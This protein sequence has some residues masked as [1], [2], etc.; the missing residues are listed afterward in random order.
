MSDFKCP[1]KVI[2]VWID[3]DDREVR[4]VEPCGAQLHL[5]WSFDWPLC[6]DLPNPNIESG[7]IAQMAYTDGWGVV[8]ENG[9]KLAM[10]AGQ[11]NAEA[12]SIPQTMES[13]GAL[14]TFDKTKMR[15]SEAL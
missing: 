4:E 3:D 1:L 2:N 6:D 9:H 10:S 13:V 15:V 7:D 12:V 14:V 8:C 11:E 5:V